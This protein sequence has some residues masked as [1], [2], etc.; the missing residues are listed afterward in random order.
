IDNFAQFNRMPTQSFTLV[1]FAVKEEAKFFK[2]LARARSDI[3]ILLTG[4]GPAN[5][6]EALHSFFA[7]NLP[8]LVVTA[9]FTRGLKPGLS[10]GTVLVETHADN[11][12]LHTALAE[13]GAL[14][15]KFHFARRVA[16]LSSEKQHLRQSSGADAVEMESHVIS[17]ICDGR[18][19]P[20]V[21]VRVVL[22]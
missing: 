13:A 22:D 14:S 8:S 21:T 20:C 5:A 19:V 12:A 10:R 1:C 15:A 9:G 6:E 16:T 2:P 7:Q 4:M 11:A 3:Q 18:Q 17:R